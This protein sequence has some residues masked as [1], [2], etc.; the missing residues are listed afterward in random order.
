MSFSSPV[1]G[2][3]LGRGHQ[4]NLGQGA[5]GRGASGLQ[6]P[7][8]RSMPT[9][10]RRLV[11]QVGGVFVDRR[12]FPGIRTGGHPAQ[13]QHQV[14]AG[15]LDVELERIHRRTARPDRIHRI[16]EQGQQGLEDR[17]MGGRPLGVHGLD[18]GLERQVCML[19]GTEDGELRSGQQVGE[20]GRA[21]E[22][23]SAPGRC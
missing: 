16:V 6:Q 12:H 18:Q 15:R 7:H 21:A 13:V 5:F 20:G 3:G 1:E 8:E 14:E 9:Q 23:G 11:E 19:E 4:R 10:D 2:L 17:R 22:I